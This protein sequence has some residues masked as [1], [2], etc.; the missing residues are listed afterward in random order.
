MAWTVVLAGPA[1]TSLKHVP[2]RETALA[3]NKN[4]VQANLDGAMKSNYRI[5]YE[6][7]ATVLS[8]PGK[9]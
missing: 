5:G 3:Q 9:K 7:P 6:L 1:R 4:P 2:A 8:L